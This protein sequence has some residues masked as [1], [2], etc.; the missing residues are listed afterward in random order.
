MTGNA[1]GSITF[2]NAVDGKSICIFEPIKFC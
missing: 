1:D 2:W